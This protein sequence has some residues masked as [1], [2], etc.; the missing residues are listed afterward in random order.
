[1]PTPSGLLKTGDRLRYK[2]SGVVCVVTERHGQSKADYSVTL[3]REDGEPFAHDHWP[4]ARKEVKL[5][6][7][8]YWVFMSGRWE[9]LS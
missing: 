7:A 5:G 3:V 8:H 9:V 2:E 4:Y 1:M 6:E